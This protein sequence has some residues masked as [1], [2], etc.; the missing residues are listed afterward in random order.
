[1]AV[2]FFSTKR[3][4]GIIVKGRKK[5]ENRSFSNAGGK[6][7]PQREAPARRCGLDVS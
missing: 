3:G 1:M 7:S 4:A 6:E 2:V 5:G